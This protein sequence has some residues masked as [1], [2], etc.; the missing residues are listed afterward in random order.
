[1]NRIR[2]GRNEQLVK[3]KGDQPA[4]TNDGTLGLDWLCVDGCFLGGGDCRSPT[5]AQIMVRTRTVWLSVTRTGISVGDSEK[6]LCP[7]GDQQRGIR[8]EVQRSPLTKQKRSEVEGGVGA[9][10][11]RI[12]VSSQPSIPSITVPIYVKEM[13][14]VVACGQ[15]IDAH[16]YRN[17]VLSLT[18]SLNPLM[19]N[20]S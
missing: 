18:Y 19:T 7:W 1:M 9:H 17:R 6:T 13:T 5:V 15:V 3:A 8:R 4:R 10:P 11:P 2:I 14:R 20:L 12:F 16:P